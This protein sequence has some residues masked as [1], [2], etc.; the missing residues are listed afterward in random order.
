MEPRISIVTL[1]VTDLKRSIVFYRDGLGLP[2][3]GWP[4]EQIAFFKTSAT[5]LALFP[6]DALAAD[7]TVPATGSG[8]QRFTLAHNLRSREEVNR[9]L[10]E[11]Q[12]AGASIVRPAGGTDWGGYSGYFADPDGFLWE[13]AWNGHFSIE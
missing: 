11:A 1:G 6:C 13:I 7:A 12:A 8:F 10:E 2:M 9:T 4:S 5:W 3:H